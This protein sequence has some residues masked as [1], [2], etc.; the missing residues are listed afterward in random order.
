MTE[1]RT[2]GGYR[3]LRALGS[4][5]MGAVYE[6]VD[7]DGR[8]VA[9][10]LLH[11]H[12]AADPAARTRLAREVTLL[13]RVRDTGVAQ[14]LD[15]EVEDA[16]AFVVTELIDGPTLEEDVA[17]DGAYDADELSGLADGLAEA[18]TA[19][20]DAGVLHR[21]LKPS[22]VML[23]DH[24]PVL[25]DFGIAQVADDVRLTQTGMVTGTPGYLAPEVVE[26]Q[27]PSP[28]AD[29]WAWAAVLT[30]AATG[31]PPF[32][33]GSTAA[34]LGRVATGHV[35]VA[36]LPETV[37][38]ALRAA[39]APDPE[40]RLGPAEVLRVLDGGPLPDGALDDEPGAAARTQTLTSGSAGPVVYLPGA[41]GERPTQTLP[42]LGGG[43]SQR[44][45]AAPGYGPPATQPYD[46]RPPAAQASGPTAALPS[47]GAVP[48]TAALPRTTA[49][50]P[51][52][53]D[54]RTAVFP[55]T[56]PSGAGPYGGAP[57]GG[58]YGSA[59][60]SRYGGPS[61]DPYGVPQPGPYGAV[62]PYRSGAP[63]VAANPADAMPAWAKPPVPRPLITAAG[64]LALSALAV[65]WPG[66]FVVVAVT[67][68]LVLGTVGRAGRARRA[69]RFKF[70]PRRGDTA[71]MYAGLPWHGVRAA[72]GLVP[73]LLV[74]AVTAVVVYLVGGWVLVDGIA[75]G[76]PLT[77]V[78]WAAAWLGLLAAWIAAPSSR[79]G[80]RSTVA[81]L[82]PGPGVRVTAIVMLLI[83]AAVGLEP[84]LLGGFPDPVWAPLPTPPDPV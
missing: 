16:E 68:L 27:D 79:E 29:W 81:A 9:L 76:L 41:G 43:P 70:G 72:V 58:P 77:A 21:D 52:A 30:F 50:P 31:R 59:V 45:S 60:R 73:G 62:D 39:L 74:G 17:R 15:A 55:A 78:R 35:D 4:G 13:H 25:I 66:T 82:L 42:A 1:E 49:F 10:K 24:G 71:R 5:G 61:A 64:G 44:A 33:R 83:A 69:A 23:S 65:R 11:P 48:G 67:V 51:G 12:I 56:P 40:R 8:H 57:A 32:G 14:V 34:V 26:G 84:A 36:G 46:A 75:P 28:A 6:A 18:L 63:P 53:G 19:I 38:G 7:G 80:A 54:S 2:V 20:H 37:A 3:L 22:N 47:A